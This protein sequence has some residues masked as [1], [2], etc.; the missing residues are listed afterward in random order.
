MKELDLEQHIRQMAERTVD[1]E[2]NAG[3]E[4]PI[5]TQYQK[6]VRLGIKDADAIGFADWIAFKSY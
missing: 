6:Y 5:R 3:C 4:S 1:R 2:T